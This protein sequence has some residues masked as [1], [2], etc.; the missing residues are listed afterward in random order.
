MAN[1]HRQ[2]ELC[3]APPSDETFPAR[4][5]L[6][7]AVFMND[8]INIPE[9]R[10]RAGELL[11]KRSVRVGLMLSVWTIMAFFFA[12]QVYMLYYREEKPVPF[13]RALFVEGLGC[14]LWAL[15]TPL[16]L[17]LARRFRIGRNNWRRRVPLHFLIALGLVML[18]STSSVLAPLDMTGV[19]TEVMIRWLERLAQGEA[20]VIF[21]DGSQTM[22]FVYVGD[23]ARAYLLAALSDATDDFLNVGS[24]TETSLKELCRLMC[25][26][27]GFPDLEPEYREARK[28]NG[29]TRRRAATSHARDAIGFEARVGLPE[30]LRELVA[31]YTE[32][33]H[34][35]QVA[36]T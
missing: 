15:S 1:Q 26:E 32:L 12:T 20:P 18:S 7:Q 25:R 33:T 19:Y 16:V 27:A 10:S 14:F 30:G 29:V 2:V 9:E 17:W 34:P 31:W 8:S 24:G 22:D 28:V 36:V 23:V 13:K 11:Q 21:G 35:A 5:S 4:R 3:T 6:Q